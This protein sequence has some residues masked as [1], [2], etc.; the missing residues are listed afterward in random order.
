MHGSAGLG[1]R[2]GGRHV[3]LVEGEDGS[4]K[5]GGGV[6]RGLQMNWGGHEMSR[7]APA[8]GEYIHVSIRRPAA[9]CAK[10]RRPPRTGR[11]GW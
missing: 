10:L 7:N 2:G 9:A 4:G 8:L 1:V 5:Q 3:D 11:L 6:L